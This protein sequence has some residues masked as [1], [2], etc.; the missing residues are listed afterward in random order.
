MAEGTWQPSWSSRAAVIAAAVAAGVVAG[1]GAASVAVAT[2]LARSVVRRDDARDRPVR[3][4]RV[5]REGDL[6]VAWLEGDGAA[7]P[8]IYS[9]LFDQLGAEPGAPKI[10]EMGHARL[11]EVV[12]RR[13]NSVARPII[14]VDR[15][16]LA[17]GVRGRMTGWWFTD[18]S[19]LGYSVE[20]VM[21]PS[22]LGDMQAWIIRPKFRRKKRWA[23]H[24]HGRGAPLEETLRGIE[25]LARAG[26]TSLVIQYRN[27]EGAP[28][29]IGDRYGL[30]L[31]E[32]RDV[33]AAIAEAV[34]RGAER[35][36]LVGWSMGG[37]ACLVAATQGAHRNVID[38]VVLDSPGVDWNGLLASNG[39]DMRVPLW[40]TGLG[41]EL[42][43][44]GIVA[45]GEP[46]GL[47]FESLTPKRFAEALSVPV[48]IQA[49]TADRVVPIAG[50]RELARLRPELVQLREVDRAGHV[51]LWNVDRDAWER[52]VH[53]FVAALPRPAWRG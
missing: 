49:S 7:T 51:R 24:V 4:S 10:S 23:I 31:S 12:T 6:P 3:V 9:L 35:V 19:E 38:G 32:S 22:E 33:D 40:V 43:E 53:T 2:H 20:A 37:T 48:L 17:P 18:P 1:V 13:G 39:S 36:T 8:G 47:D 34:S 44:R 21:Y 42:I 41:V 14:A 5:S 28:G 26:I 27:D 30:G 15:G 11:G 45:S 25:P 50:A 52:T 29:G 16:T 46:Q